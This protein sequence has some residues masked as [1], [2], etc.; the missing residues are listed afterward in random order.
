MANSTKAE[1]PYPAN[2]L[3]TLERAGKRRVTRRFGRIM[4][5]LLLV[6]PII[7]ALVPWQQNLAGQ[8]QITDF[9]PVNRPM[10]L[11]ARTKGLLMKWHVQEG[12]Y[13]KQGDPIVDLADNDPDIIANYTDQLAAAQNKLAAA[14][15]KRDQFEQQAASAELARTAAMQYADDEIAAAVQA[16]NVSEQGA[17]AAREKLK[18]AGVAL[19]MWQ[20]LVADRIGAGFELQKAKQ[21]RNVAEADLKAKLAEIDGK[22]ASLRAKRSARERI[23]RSELVKV[24][25]AKA[26]RDSAAGDVATAEGSLPKLR[27]DLA[28]QKQQQLTA[29]IDGFVQNLAANGQG[30]GFVKEGETLAMLVPT[31]RQLAV[32]LYVDGNDVTF[33]DV[34]RHVRLQFEGWPAVQWVGWPSAAIGT[35]G[36]KVAFVDRSD[37]NGT[38]KFRV[39]VLPDERPFVEH[40]GPVVD[41]LR[42]V[43]TFEN[44]HTPDNPHAWPG[45]EYLRQGVRV[46][47][48]VVLDRVSLGFEIW[49]Q[50]NGFPPTID[51]PDKDGTGKKEGGK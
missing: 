9:N 6:T 46:K 35:F 27:R 45:D 15:Q 41:W 36:G 12:Q 10:P 43:L 37:K 13:V 33:I 32:E 51:R 20:G 47:G 38:G 39:M 22:K 25:G 49:R 40:E 34:G 29:P 30:G 23:E 48:W 14:Q 2:E 26:K 8:G 31:S 21:A 44:K 50:L 1:F 11:Q 7:M 19:E 18:L 17:A 24:Q 4:L 5:L 3:A 16:V 42:S 28:R